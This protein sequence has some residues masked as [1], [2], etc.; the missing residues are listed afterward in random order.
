VAVPVI[1]VAVAGGLLGGKVSLKTNP[2]K[3]KKIFAYT[4]LA[5][6][7]FMFFNAFMSK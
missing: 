5:A 1:I 4:T 6:A 7:V 3:L 2:E